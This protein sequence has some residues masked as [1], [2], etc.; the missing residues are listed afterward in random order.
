MAAIDTRERQRLTTFE[1]RLSL[2]PETIL[3]LIEQD[4]STSHWLVSERFYQAALKLD[5]DDQQWRV[6]RVMVLKA[7]PEKTLVPERMAMSAISG[8]LDS[9]RASLA[10]FSGETP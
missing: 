10:Q 8:K 7:L 1:S 4:A 2:D 6:D 9:S 5:G 3:A